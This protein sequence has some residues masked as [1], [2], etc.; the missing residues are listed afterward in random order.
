[1]RTVWIK[2]EG[3]TRQPNSFVTAHWSNSV[4]QNHRLESVVRT[5]FLIVPE[6]TRPTSGTSEKTSSIWKERFSSQANLSNCWLEA[7]GGRTL[8]NLCN[9]SIPAPV[10]LDTLNIGTTLKY[11]DMTYTVSFNIDHVRN[12]IFGYFPKQVLCVDV[13]WILY[14]SWNDSLKMDCEN[15]TFL[16]IWHWSYSNMFYWISM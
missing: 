6:I 15:I 14:E 10:L 2:L 13:R 7:V 12:Q 11:D 3:K 4:S 5:Y 1:M 8:R 16:L 9:K